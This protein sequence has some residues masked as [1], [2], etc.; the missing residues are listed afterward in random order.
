MPTGL[1]LAAQQQI[2]LVQSDHA[3]GPDPPLQAA[4]LALLPAQHT[5]FWATQNTD[6]DAPFN[7]PMLTLLVSVAP[8]CRRLGEGGAEQQQGSYDNFHR[9]LLLV[10]CSDGVWTV[11]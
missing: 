10:W 7:A 2:T 4:E 3:V 1:M 8:G 9:D 5:R 11:G 6:R